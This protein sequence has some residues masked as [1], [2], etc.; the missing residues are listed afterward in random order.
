MQKL[1]DLLHE[2]DL[3]LQTNASAKIGALRTEVF[4]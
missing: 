4:S 3:K 1:R 2:K